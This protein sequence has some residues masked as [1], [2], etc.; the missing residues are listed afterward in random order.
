MQPA[1]RGGRPTGMHAGDLAHPLTAT[2]PLAHSAAALACVLAVVSGLAAA[3]C[4]GS[5][6]EASLPVLM[7]GHFAATAASRPPGAA[8]S[9]GQL[10]VRRPGRQDL[11]G[12]R[13][14]PQPQPAA[15]L[16]RQ[17]RAGNVSDR[18][19]ALTDPP[20]HIVRFATRRARPRGDQ[21][22]SPGECAEAARPAGRPGSQDRP[23]GGNTPPVM[24]TVVRL[25]PDPLFCPG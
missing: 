19:P 16:A 24:N 11:P 13:L 7:R 15:G 12:A 25:L 6:A 23:R 17:P 4:A 8:A 20:H 3:G 21:P 5:L 10:P 2:R 1:G 14:R 22:G 18:S 9:A